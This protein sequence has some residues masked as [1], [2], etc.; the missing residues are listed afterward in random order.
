MIKSSTNLNWAG[1]RLKKAG[2]LM[3]IDRLQQKIEVGAMFR[4]FFK[5][6]VDH[7]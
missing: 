2:K 3:V 7:V 5:V 4:E 1:G 6:L